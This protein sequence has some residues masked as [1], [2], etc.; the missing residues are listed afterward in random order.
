MQGYEIRHGSTEATSPALH[1]ALPSGLG[2]VSG[3]VLGVYLHG[4]F[5]SDDVLAA[6]SGRSPTP[7]DAVFDHLADVVDE[8]LDQAW[9][10]RVIG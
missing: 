3:H 7:L 6:F 1:P 8:H 5:E 2:Y 4:L 10:D 9:L